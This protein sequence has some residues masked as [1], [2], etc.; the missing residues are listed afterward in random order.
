MRFLIQSIL[1]TKVL[2]AHPV[3]ENNLRYTKYKKARVN[4]NSETD[5]SYRFMLLHNDFPKLSGRSYEPFSPYDKN[6]VEKHR[7]EILAKVPKFIQIGS[8]E[9]EC[10]INKII[11]KT[12]SDVPIIDSLRG[13]GHL[14]E[15]NF[16]CKS[17]PQYI[18]NQI[19]SLAEFDS[20]SQNQ[21]YCNGRHK[22]TANEHG[23]IN[24]SSLKCFQ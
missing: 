6:Y 12:F 21:V 5:G 22:L 17:T 2:C 23:M 14:L 7:L 11:M 13:T 20:T 15:A 16:T 10:R 19:S 24:L 8:P 3:V 4:L 9:E 1:L 18:V